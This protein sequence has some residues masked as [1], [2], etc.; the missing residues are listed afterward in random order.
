MP[1]RKF[2]E[3]IK[4][5]EKGQID[6]LTNDIFKELGQRYLDKFGKK[7]GIFHK[8]QSYANQLIQ[9]NLLD[10]QTA[11]EMALDVLE[12]LPD[13]DGWLAEKLAL[14]TRSTIEV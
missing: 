10:N 3:I 9:G 13:V 12:S 6:T 14:T 2:G 1:A 5:V 4:S 11:P 7:A 8:R